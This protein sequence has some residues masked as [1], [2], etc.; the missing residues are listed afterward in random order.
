MKFTFHLFALVTLLMVVA[1]N[2]SPKSASHP[3]GI[4]LNLQ[5]TGLPD[6]TQMEIYLGA[7]GQPESPL[8]SC[9][10]IDG[11]AQFAFDVEGPRM[12]YISAAGTYGLMPVVMDKGQ[13]ATLTAQATTESRSGSD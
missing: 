12:Y 2:P 1:C 4:V 3:E 10:L 11:K 7:T 8:Q 6:G 9:P 5:I 13:E